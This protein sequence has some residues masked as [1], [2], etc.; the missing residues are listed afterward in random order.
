M[1][2]KKTNLREAFPDIPQDIYQG[3]MHT[4]HSVREDSPKRHPRARTALMAALV[5]V[6]SMA[7]AY[8][9]FP[10]QL[11]AFFGRLYG[12]QTQEW[13]EQ[14]RLA[15]PQDSITLAGLAFTMD[16]V[17]YHNRGLYGLVKVTGAHPEQ[18][19]IR[20]EK[21]GADQGEMMIPL[22]SV[23]YS[24]ESPED[25]SLLLSFEVADGS[26]IGQADSFTLL[27]TAAV[28]EERQ[29]WLVQVAPQQQ[30]ANIETE[31]ITEQVTK[32][33]LEQQETA[34]YKLNVPE[35]Y[36][37]TGTLPVYAAIKR[38]FT[39]N[40]RPELFNSSGVVEQDHHLITYQDEATLQFGAEA[41]YYNEYKGTY[42]GNYKHP[43]REPT[44]L[45][46]GTLD[47]AAASL[48]SHVHFG[49]PNRGQ[50]WEGI[51]LD[52]TALTGI[53]LEEAQAKL[54]A[55]L[56][57]L[58]VEGY[59]LTWALD[60][61]LER[62][63]A[64]GSIQ[65]DLHLENVYWNTPMYDYS[66]AT[67]ANEGFYL[68]YENG[69]KSSEK[70]FEVSAYITGKGITYLV[71]RDLY[72]K[73]DIVARP[74]Q[75][76]SPEDVLRSLPKEMARSQ[77]SDLTLLSVRSVELTW[78]PVRAPDKAQGMV[79]TPAWYITYR[80]SGSLVKGPYDAYALFNAVDGTLISAIFQ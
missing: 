30:S 23:G 53:T 54:E 18:A 42:N 50:S 64:L 12:R 63:Q 59:H 10:S 24:E 33:A 32:P 43:D 45:K 78:A 48:A 74:E 15:T 73:G 57:E 25:G 68:V 1:K 75:L 20:I 61:D 11:T 56:K 72:I 47:M 7:V 76:V 16:E 6:A 60:M 40:L 19:S 28:G 21:I 35:I 4:A 77:F 27:L 44:T 3:L 80:D 29:E 34:E 17:V 36:E 39:A 38:D 51:Q 22:S 2:N 26:I 71:I 8:A 14:G 52:K 67:S 70:F 79:M 66:Q 62:I 41:L 9:A 46:L 5:L 13:L 49:S 37:Q 69:I 58:Q 31:T 55:L 65:N